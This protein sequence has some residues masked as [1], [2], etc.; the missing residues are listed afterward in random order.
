MWKSSFIVRSV[1]QAQ[2]VEPRMSWDD[3][4]EDE[5][6]HRGAGL[7][8]E[9][10]PR[11][12][13]ANSK[14]SMLVLLWRSRPA[15]MWMLVSVYVG[16]KGYVC[17][18][19]R[20][21][22]LPLFQEYSDVDSNV[23]Q[24]YVTVSMLP[25]AMKGLFGVASDML[26]FGQYRK[27]YWGILAA[28]VGTVGVVCLN[29]IDVQENT[30]AVV[31]CFMLGHFEVAVVDLLMEGKYAELG[32]ET[33]K[34]RGFY[35]S[36]VWACATG[37]G[38]VGS[39]L[40]GV[41]ADSGHIYSLLW[42]VVPFAAQVMIPFWLGWLP[43]DSVQDSVPAVDKIPEHPCQSEQH[44]PLMETS[45]DSVANITT[46]YFLDTKTLSDGNGNDDENDA[47]EN[48]IAV[49]ENK[50]AAWDADVRPK[51]FS[52][53]GD[54]AWRDD[55]EYEN[56]SNTPVE[57][58]MFS[59]VENEN[60][61]Q[62]PENDTIHTAIENDTIRDIKKGS[63][64]YPLLRISRPQE[65]YDRTSTTHFDVHGGVVCKGNHW[66]QISCGIIS[67]NVG[68]WKQHYRL[69]FLAIAMSVSVLVLSVI[70]L[71][72]SE[73]DI[74]MILMAGTVSVI[75]INI[76][77]WSMDTD[78]AKS[79][80]FMFLLAVTYPSIE[81]VLDYYYTTDSGCIA[82]SPHLDYKFYT[83]YSSIAQG[84][85]G[86]LGIAL[87]YRMH[88]Q[89]SYRKMFLFS[90]LLKPFGAIIDIL[91]ISR[92]VG[93][94]RVLF[95]VGFNV[96]GPV[97]GA[98][99]TM[100]AVLL[101]TELCPKSI[102]ATV[103]SLLAS[104]QNFG[105]GISSVIGIVAIHLSGVVL[106][107]AQAR[108]QNINNPFR[109]PNPQLPYLFPITATT[110]NSVGSFL[111]TLSPNNVSSSMIST[112]GHHDHSML[113]PLPLEP[114]QDISFSACNI[115][116]LIFLIVVCHIIFPLLSIPLMYKL[117]KPSYTRQYTPLRI[118][119]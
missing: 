3:E 91:I 77:F 112:T 50:I 78:L 71:L 102:E 5:S 19:L 92:S 7:L 47:S 59:L 108:S 65:D 103:Y 1:K 100:P 4:D 52:C 82:D 109:V 15:F 62:K 72:F 114:I 6:W 87:F 66:R 56:A 113:I 14:T 9:K 32:R 8:S 85:F 30:R 89:W 17:S 106:H 48:K 27:R 63:K 118:T 26:A 2:S 117:I 98:F 36:F 80:F 40:V 84:V 69:V 119:T 97:L 105:R 46:T 95:M 18:V 38:L 51:L 96:I 10:L 25:W 45:V 107:S 41:L 12:K 22:Q 58:G 43:Q 16:L 21:S 86:I 94:D 33:P 42:T 111:S 49:S 104:F 88:T 115:D 61:S 60:N 68:A 37:G 73:N 34:H 83:T 110:N 53:N 23:Y 101:T 55:N 44:A 57:N 11:Q 13:N 75:I 99:E 64:G 29:I 70:T 31:G 76:S 79:N 116:N 54:E 24:A 81:G 67:A 93:Y 90:I 35:V 28:V 74:I 39:I 20:G